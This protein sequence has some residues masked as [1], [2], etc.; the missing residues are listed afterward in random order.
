MPT[1]L[2]PKMS[3]GVGEWA[4]WIGGTR[5][6]RLTEADLIIVRW[7]TSNNPGVLNDAPTLVRGPWA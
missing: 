5:T 2:L 3:G 6:E 7:L 4:R 1:W